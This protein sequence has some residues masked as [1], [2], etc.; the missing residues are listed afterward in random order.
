VS[1]VANDQPARRT[2]G[3]TVVGLLRALLPSLV[4]VLVLVWWQRGDPRPVP[5]VDP[6]PEIAHA[7]RISPTPLPVP[8]TL[9]TGWRATS[10]RVDAPSGEGRSPVTLSVGYLTPADK[11]AQVVI[12]DRPVGRLLQDAAP[13]ATV[14]GTEPAAPAGFTRYRTGRGEP[15]LVAERGPVTVLVTGD[16]SVQDL[17]LLAQSVR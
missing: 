17:T 16:A 10:A 3:R 6:R 2:T 14:D 15:A 12:S 4:V 11:F 13:G 5:T 8:G 1:T 9:P 7:Q